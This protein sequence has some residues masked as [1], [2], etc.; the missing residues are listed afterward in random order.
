MK[1]PYHE[2]RR[3]AV[4]SA[5]SLA[6]PIVF[7][8]R[9]LPAFSSQEPQ[10]ILAQL[11]GKGDGISALGQPWSTSCAW[12]VQP[13]PLAAEAEL[14]A[15][16]VGSWRVQS[17][18]DGVAF[19]LGR[20]YIGELTPGARMASILTLPNI[21][22]APKFDLVFGAVERGGS[23]AARPLRGDNAKAVL[24]AFWPDAS[25]V[26]VQE[27]EPSERG[28]LR[29]TYEAPTRT[30]GR[31]QQSIDARSAPREPARTHPQ[32]R[33]GRGASN[34]CPISDAVRVASGA[35]C[36]AEGGAVS[37]DEWVVAEV[38]Q[39][40]NVEQGVRTQYL[41]IQ[42]YRRD[43]AAEGVVR[44][45]QRVAAFLQPTDGRYF[46]AAGKPVALYDYSFT[47]RKK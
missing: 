38:V 47:L 40:S 43:P 10:A 19:P 1:T 44:S 41:V 23:G 42:S 33:L 14:P 39:Q 13:P 46:D 34:A 18:L 36:V 6:V 32:R 22:N 31:L 35:A 25:V 11:R 37:E 8:G 4:L 26:S 45:T 7:N 29:L 27:G 3:R 15:W 28:R 24:E 9:S 2:P 30:Q 12:S 16:L 20:G 17:K 21:G 5:L